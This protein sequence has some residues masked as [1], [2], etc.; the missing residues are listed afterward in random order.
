MDATRATR[1]QAVHERLSSWAEND[2]ATLAELLHRL[3]AEFGD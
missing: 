2:L 1:R 3:D